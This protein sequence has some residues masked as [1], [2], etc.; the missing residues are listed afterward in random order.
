M[1]QD[2]ENFNFEQYPFFCGYRTAGL[3]NAWVLLDCSYLTQNMIITPLFLSISTV[4][5]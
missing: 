2:K 4:A 3:T 5:T 1:P